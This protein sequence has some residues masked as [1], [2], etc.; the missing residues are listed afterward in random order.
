MSLVIDVVSSVHS[1]NP[2]EPLDHLLTAGFMTER[3]RLMDLPP[4]THRAVRA[5]EPRRSDAKKRNREAHARNG[6]TKGRTGAPLD[7]YEGMRARAAKR[8]R[9]KGG[10]VGDNQG[11]IY[12]PRHRAA[13]LQAEQAAQLVDPPPPPTL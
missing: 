2:P 10:W 6:N 3:R 1:A 8:P 4:D 7:L 12:E 13:T 5:R 9:Q 11:I